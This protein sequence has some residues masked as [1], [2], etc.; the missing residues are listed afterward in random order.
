MRTLL[1]L[2]LTGLAMGTSAAQESEKGGSPNAPPRTPVLSVRFGCH[3]N[4]T[5][6]QL[7]QLRKYPELEELDILSDKIT[8]DGLDVLKD[9]GK[10]KKVRLN[11]GKITDKGVERLKSLP[12]IEDL[13][14]FRTPVTPD[15]LAHLKSIPS[16]RRLHLWRIP[17][18]PEV[19]AQLK[20]LSKLESLGF[21]QLTPESQ[22]AAAGLVSLLPKTKVTFSK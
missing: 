14:L 2:W 21:G 6:E 9:L 10:L 8:D 5:D 7:A 19:V 16:L 1:A 11:S 20:E 18:T 22:S 12:V 3:S 17:I 4:V 13:V 15:G